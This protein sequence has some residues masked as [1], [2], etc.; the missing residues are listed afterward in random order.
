MLYM[1]KVDFEIKKTS[2]SELGRDEVVINLNN[3][4]L[5]KISSGEL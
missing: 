4:E 2:P 5:K 3:I 1:P